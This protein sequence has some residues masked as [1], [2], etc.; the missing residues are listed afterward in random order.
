MA[1][2]ALIEN[3]LPQIIAY[4]SIAIFILTTNSPLLSKYIVLIIG[5]YYI[6]C[7][8]LADFNRGLEWLTAGLVSIE[9][10]QN[11]LLKN[12]INKKEVKEYTGDDSCPSVEVNNLSASYNRVF[13]CI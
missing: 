1:L 2:N 10:M 7:S 8:A 6:I 11:Y 9:R 4:V 5:N 3:V 12:E 13:I